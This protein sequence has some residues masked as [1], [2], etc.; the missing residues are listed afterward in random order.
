MNTLLQFWWRTV[1]RFKIR[2]G[3]STESVE[4]LP[5]QLVPKRVYLVGSQNHPWC[6]ALLCPCG[7]GETIQLS[8]IVGDS[9]T[10]QAQRHF[11]GSVSLR[12][13]IRRIQG[14]RSHFF[15]RRGHINWLDC[16]DNRLR[17]RSI[18]RSFFQRLSRHRNRT[19]YR[20]SITN[21]LET[22]K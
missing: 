21:S 19:Q 18:L 13:S 2:S 22:E 12:P 17:F 14:C 4:E 7:C 20:T 5:L 15:L 16:C 6:I 11:S 1:E 10:W 8:L 9:P 3:Q